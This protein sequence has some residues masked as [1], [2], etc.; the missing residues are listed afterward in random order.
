MTYKC[1]N[2]LLPMKQ[3]IRL[4]LILLLPLYTYSQ[5]KIIDSTAY[6]KWPSVSGPVI[7]NDGRYVMYYQNDSSGVTLQA[8]QSKLRKQINSRS[9]CFFTTDNKKLIY[10]LPGDSLAIMTIENSSIDYLDNVES[11]DLVSDGKDQLLIWLLRY[12]GKLLF[13]NLRTGSHRVIEHVTSFKA[14][15]AKTNILLHIKSDEDK[16]PN[17]VLKWFD[18]VN[19]TLY[20]IADFTGSDYVFDKKEEAV[21]FSNTSKD[22]NEKKYWIYKAGMNTPQMIFVESALVNDIGF[23]ISWIDFNSDSDRVFIT[24][25]K[26]IGALQED[27]MLSVNIWSYTDKELQSTQ[28]RP[29]PVWE[30]QSKIIEGVFSLKNH[31]FIQLTKCGEHATAKNNNFWL[32]SKLNGEMAEK[33]WNKY[34]IESLFLVST[35]DGSVSKLPG[36]KGVGYEIGNS[37]LLYFD[38]ADK[39]YY[40]FQ[41]STNKKRCITKNIHTN[42]EQ[43][44]ADLSRSIYHS[45]PEILPVAA[46]LDS[47]QSV[48]LYDRYDIWQLDLNNKTSPVNLTKGYGRRHHICFRLLGDDNPFSRTIIINNTS[49]IICAFNCVTKQNGFY[50]IKT[51]ESSN[52]ELL[53]MGNYTYYAPQKNAVSVTGQGMNPLKA[54]DTAAYIISRQSAT[55]YP[56]FFYTTDFKNFRQLSDLAPQRN[57][58]WMTTEL[59]SWTTPDGIKTQG[60]LYKPENFDSSNKYPVIFDI[61]EL[62]SDNLYNFLMPELAAARIDIPT[63]VSR[64]YLVFAPDI[65]YIKNKTFESTYNT[66]VSAVKALSKFSFIDKKKLGLQGHSWGGIQAY[67]MVTHTNLF[68]A[69]CAASGMTDMVSLSGITGNGNVIMDPPFAPETGQIRAPGTLWDDPQWYIRNSAIMRAD[70]VTTPFLMMHGTKDQRVPVGQAIEFFTAMRRLGKK[71]WLLEYEEENHVIYQHKQA[72]RDYVIRL[73]QFFD[74]YLKNAPAPEW[75]VEGVP[76]SEKGYMS[77][78]ELEPAGVVP[79]PGILIPAIQK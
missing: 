62:R 43:V 48:L 13:H 35:K 9:L 12:S 70:K 46:W 27:K 31:S 5:K 66:I 39:N 28:M 29:R 47:G 75:M 1:L 24:L 33:Y 20:S 52:P 8:T 26:P 37:F 60:I 2:S 23:K 25:A 19:D 51:G 49:L 54:K 53:T 50:K 34:S 76:A 3:A 77:G 38:D 40:S 32:V 78:L 71:A 59:V 42:W 63:F 15:P 79:G 7:S 44:S 74:N 10:K 57:F 72:T 41:Y 6:D 22:H 73:Q 65:Y 68:A 14:S 30:S 55:E 61:Y 58:N 11:F 67:Y 16:K 64:G 56:N 18:L 4:L 21:I 69:I 45:L 36:K 17:D